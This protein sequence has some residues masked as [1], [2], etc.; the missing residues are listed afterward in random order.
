MEIRFNKKLYPV[1]AIKNAI[2]AYNSLA[3]FVLSDVEDYFVVRINN[4]ET[5]IEPVL[6]DEFCNYVLAQVKGSDS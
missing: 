2:E 5:E 3:E 4:I 1:A 6:K